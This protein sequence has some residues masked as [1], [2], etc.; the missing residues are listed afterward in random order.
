MTAP[1][2]EEPGRGRGGRGDCALSV[3]IPHLNQ[4]GML[5]RC[6][7]SIYRQPPPPG[8]FEVIVIDNGSDIPIEDALDRN[9]FPEVRLDTEETPGPG[10]ARNRGVAM[11]RAPVLAFIDADCVAGGDWLQTIH[12]A[13]EERPGLAVAGGNVKLLVKDPNRLTPTEAYESVFAYR[14]RYY[15]ERVGFCATLNMAVR[16][17]VFEQVGPFGG[18]EIAEDADWGR[19]AVALG[20]SLTYLPEMI[21]FH[22]ARESLGALCRKWDRILAHDYQDAAARSLGRVRWSI[23]AVM[24]ALSAGAH[25][26]KVLG[27]DRLPN[28]RSRLAGLAGLWRVRLHRSKRMLSHALRPPAE[29]R[30]QTWNR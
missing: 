17:S 10:P 20:I 7:E 26:I 5:E 25:A 6:L 23:R 8:G 30:P 19:R 2:P 9:R 11:A 18:I 14:Q 21:V 1:Q 15:V 27:T 3:I 29:I 16:K 4:L 22:P 13:F 12:R 24:V 28:F